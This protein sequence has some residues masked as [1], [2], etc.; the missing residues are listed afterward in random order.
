MNVRALATVLSIA[1][2]GC[3]LWGFDIWRD[4]QTVVEIVR[5][6]PL[7]SLPPHEYPAAN[8]TVAMLQPGMPVRV[9]RTRY[10]KDFQAFRVETDKGVE[11]WIIHDDG[12][13][14]TQ[15]AT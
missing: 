1:A 15:H 3:A 7:L 10:G 8:P 9:L 13:R 6:T 2:L 5:P 11:G 4:R 12:I 14:V